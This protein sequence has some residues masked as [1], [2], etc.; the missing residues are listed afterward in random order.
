M[1]KPSIDTFAKEYVLA[2]CVNGRQS[3][4]KAGYSE[5]TADQAASRL[6]KQVKVRDLINKYKEKPTQVF[7][8]DKN[9]KLKI[10]EEVMDACKEFNVDTGVINAAAVIASIK[11]HNE[12]MGHNAPTE[13]TSTIKV[14]RSLAERLTNAS[15]R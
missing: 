14:E 15:K 1:A 11:T 10:L 13:T 7:I 5:K 9:A 4:I 3:A 2:G 6:L 12:M 8:R